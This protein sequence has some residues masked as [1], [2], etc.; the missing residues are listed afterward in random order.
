MLYK[1]VG[2]KNKKT[3]QGMACNETSKTDARNI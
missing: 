2:M 1:M 3:M